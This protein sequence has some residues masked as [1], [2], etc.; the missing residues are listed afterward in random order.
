[1]DQW[2]DSCQEAFETIKELLTTV[3]ILGVADWKFPNIL[4]RNASLAGLAEVLYQEQERRLGI[5]AYGS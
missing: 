2:T 5:M 4:R 1:M 3:L